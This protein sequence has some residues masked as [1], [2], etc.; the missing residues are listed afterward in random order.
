[1]KLTPEILAQYTDILLSAAIRKCGG[2]QDAEDLVGDTLLAALN[3]LARGE[4]VLDAEAWLFSVLRRRYNDRLRRKYRATLVSFDAGFDVADDTGVDDDLLAQETREEVRRQ[5]AFLGEQYRTCVVRHYF[6]GERIADIA[7]ALGI[8]EG[9]V[10]SRLNFG[11][12]Q[13]KKGIA[14]MQNFNELS[15]TPKYLHLC[16]SSSCG[17]NMEPMSLTGEDVLAQNLLIT[18]YE[19]PLTPADIA[20]AVGVPAAYVEPVITKLVREE[21][22]CETGDGRVYTDFIIY[23]SEDCA[24]YNPDKI[25]FCRDNQDA[26]LDEIRDVLRR[27]RETG[28]SSPRLERFILI[29]IAAAALWQAGEPH[30]KPQIFPDRP[31]GGRW[32]AFATVYNDRSMKTEIPAEKQAPRNWGMGGQR[33]THI[34]EYMGGQDLVMFNYDTALNPCGFGKLES[35]GCHTFMENEEAFLKLSYLIKKGIDPTTAGFPEKQ[36]AGIPGLCE[37]GFLARREDGSLDVSV[38]ILTHAESRQLFEDICRPAARRIAERLTGPLGEYLR[39]HRETIPAH[40]DSV[41]EQKLTMPHEPPVMEFVF[42]AIDAGLHPADIGPCPETLI[43]F[44]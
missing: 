12:K 8:P 42:R 4:E 36:L 34:R 13:M 32:I 33:N 9:T 39:T 14:E 23:R 43:V 38:P 29:D 2:L 5:V 41:P 3:A 19:K 44:D 7:A 6:R 30:R 35:L 11:R 21:L 24:K 15:H 10:K 1:M 20:R 17:R 26:Y 16:N 31:N 18:A 27:L 40:L 22:M 37:E 28:F 25:A